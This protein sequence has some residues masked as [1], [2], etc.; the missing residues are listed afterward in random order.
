MVLSF[1]MKNAF[2]VKNKVDS[3]NI[4][5]GLTFKRNP[6]DNE[7]I[8]YPSVP[9][10]LGK[11]S[12]FLFEIN[13]SITKDSEIGTIEFEKNDVAA[14]RTSFR[15]KG[16]TKNKLQKQTIVPV[17]NIKI[18]RFFGTAF[19]TLNQNGFPKNEVAGIMA[20][21]IPTWNGE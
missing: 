20:I 2:A 4:N 12:F 8:E 5:T 10:I 9:N 3:A 19:L 13:D 7:L 21:R 11:S 18:S 16:L 14:I 1:L 17:A 15:A 6:I